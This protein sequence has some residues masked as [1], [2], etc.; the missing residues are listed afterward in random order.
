MA[1]PNGRRTHALLA[2]SRFSDTMLDKTP[3]KPNG[4]SIGDRIRRESFREARD[5][6]AEGK[7]IGAETRERRN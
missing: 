3:D 6:T 1:G 5:K 2:V 7:E 4:N